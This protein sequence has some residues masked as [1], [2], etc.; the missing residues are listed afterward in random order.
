MESMQEE[1][2]IEGK[3]RQIGRIE[4]AVPGMKLNIK[5]E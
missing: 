2:P 1:F 5:I 4:V 3:R